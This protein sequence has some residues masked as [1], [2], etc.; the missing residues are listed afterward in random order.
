MFLEKNLRAFVITQFSKTSQNYPIIMFI[1]L[2]L[3]LR[4]A[5]VNPYYP[6][7]PFLYPLKTSHNTPV[8]LLTFK[9]S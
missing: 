8:F 2:V 4:T 3:E 5:F 6:N 7:V 1:V 9:T